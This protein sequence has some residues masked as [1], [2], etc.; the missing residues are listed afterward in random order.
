MANKIDHHPL[1]PPGGHYMD[2]PGLKA[3]CVDRF[4][5]ASHIKRERL[6]YA[7][8]EAIQ[9]VLIAKIPCRVWVNGSFV[10]EKPEPNDIDVMLLIELDVSKLLTEDQRIIVDKFANQSYSSVV[11]SS[12][13]TAFPSGHHLCG[14]GCDFR[15]YADV[16]GEEHSKQW[17]KGYAVLRLGET[18]VGLRLYR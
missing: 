1:L 12:A 11:D 13:Y 14:T 3:L 16:Y 2:L 7:A 8:E 15:E 9:E 4:S 18:H 10:T 17:R 5:D 6:Y